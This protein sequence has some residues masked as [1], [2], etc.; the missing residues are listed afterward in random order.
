VDSAR[1][2]EESAEQLS[3]GLTNCGIDR[4]RFPAHHFFDS[5]YSELVRDPMRIVKAIYRK[6]DFELRQDALDRMTRYLSANPQHKYG[7]HRYCLEDFGLDPERERQRFA[8]YV[9]T[10]AI[11]QEC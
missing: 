5:Y 4:S 9:N 6:F 3:L 2:A 7:V 11:P 1:L 10:F 8:D